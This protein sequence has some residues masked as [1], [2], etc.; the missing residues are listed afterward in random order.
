MFFS[1]NKARKDEK[2]AVQLGHHIGYLPY[3]H[4]EDQAFV[5]ADGGRRDSQDTIEFR[6][7]S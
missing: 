2:L 7:T 1:V 6:R 4:G 5:G 3:N